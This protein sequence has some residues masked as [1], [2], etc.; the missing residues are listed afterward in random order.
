MGKVVGERLEWVDITKGLA[1]F[2]VVIGHTSIP[3]I[4]SRFIWSFHMPLFFIVSG[5]FFNINN[6]DL[7]TQVITDFKR[8]VIPYVFFLLCYILYLVIWKEPISITQIVNGHA[9]GQIWFL[10]TLFFSHLVFFIILKY[11]RNRSCQILLIVLIGFLGFL[12]YFFNI[13]L[14]YRIEVIGLAIIHM[15]FGYYFCTFLK[16]ISFNL[17]YSICIIISVF[18]FAQI[19][20]VRLDMQSNIWGDVLNIPLAWLGTYSIMLLSKNIST[21]HENNVLRVFFNWAGKNSIT[22]LGFSAIINMSNK[23][24]IILLQLNIPNYIDSISR[25]IILWGILYI[26]TIILNRYFP[27]LIGKNKLK[28]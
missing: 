27:I 28:S 3:E 8:I 20:P 7:K 10:Q 4:G 17:F 1:I 13:H 14:P 19:T 15:S 12:A 9:V 16:N 23:Y 5:L 24:L 25:H 11:F 6:K 26:V 2:M 18:V 22:I 21:W